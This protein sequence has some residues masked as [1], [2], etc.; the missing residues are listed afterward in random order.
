[1]RS[2]DAAADAA[3]AAADAAVRCLPSLR[4]ARARGLASPRIET[5]GLRLDA[6]HH[7]VDVRVLEV[8]H[9]R[10]CET[11]RRQEGELGSGS[12]LAAVVRDLQLAARLS[13]K[14]AEAVAGRA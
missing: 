14:P 9:D 5:Y 12:G 7:R 13:E 2:A 11:A 6:R 1:M 4:A 10:D 3:A 8:A